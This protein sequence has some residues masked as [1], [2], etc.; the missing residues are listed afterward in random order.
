[1]KTARNDGRAGAFSLIEL[2]AVIA[3]IAILAALLLPALSQGRARAKR[4]QC[5]NTLRQI[6]Q[7]FEGFAQEHNGSFPMA[8][9]VSAGGSQELVQNSLLV[10]GEFYFSYRH[11]QT[12]SNGLVTPKLLVCPADTRSPATDFAALRNENVSYFVGLNAAF[13]RPNSIL[14]G[15]RNLTND[16]ST[17]ASVVR[18][19]P[20]YAL[21]WTEEL[22]RFKGNL[23]F[24][25]GHVEEKNTPGL[26]AAVGQVPV[27]AALSLPTTPAGSAGGFGSSSPP[28]GGSPV[29]QAPQASGQAAQ[30]S[31]AGIASG[32]SPGT[33]EPGPKPANS[34]PWS[35][36][37][38][39]TVERPSAVNPNGAG[40]PGS[41]GRPVPPSQPQLKQEWTNGLMATNPPAV[42][43]PGFSLFPPS[44]AALPQTLINKTPWWL[45]LL[46]LLLLVAVAIVLQHWLAARKAKAVKAEEQRTW[47]ER[48]TKNLGG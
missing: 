33:A 5:I 8:V 16:F 12:L 35:P 3:I 11:F 46:L 34:G 38:Q 26:V 23:L 15:D 41:E 7:A 43:E 24:A 13:D 20:N 22:H 6:G 48:V 39:M 18:F 17:P 45:Y 32:M 25:D 40:T 27:T 9:P 47:E 14:A 19:G 37:G 1:M 10:A 31:P 44:I 2:L 28:F 29:P 4:V 36:V 30:G 42:E 21:R